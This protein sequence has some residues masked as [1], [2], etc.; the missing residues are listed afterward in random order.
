MSFR[1]TNCIKIFKKLKEKIYE[2]ISAS[3]RKKKN[4]IITRIEALRNAENMNNC[5]YIYIYY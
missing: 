5:I 3:E 1:D 4:V 2:R